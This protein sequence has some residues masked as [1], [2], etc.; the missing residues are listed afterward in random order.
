LPFVQACYH[1]NRPILQGGYGMKT[2]VFF[3]LATLLLVGPFVVY[4]A[5]LRLNDF[6]LHTH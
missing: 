5:Y 1:R 6:F 3:A 2:K 4:M